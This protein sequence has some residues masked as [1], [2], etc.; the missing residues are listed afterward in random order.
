MTSKLACV[1]SDTSP[2]SAM[3]KMGWLPWLQ[4]R[5]GTILLPAGVWRELAEI[6]DADAHAALDAARSDGWLK[7]QPV[8]ALGREEFLNLHAGEI[9]AISMA[10]ALRA[11]WL[12]VDDGDARRVALS[13]GVPICGLIGMIVWAKQHGK[14]VKVLDSIADLRR[15][16]KFRISEE[17][18]GRIARDLGETR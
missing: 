13:L 15:I 8:A 6:G 12:L 14:V 5:W 10:V 2:L 18:I 4:E 16:T 9:E 11:D 1:V 7:V 3:A 17:V